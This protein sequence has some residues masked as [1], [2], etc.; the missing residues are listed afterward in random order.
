MKNKVITF[1]KVLDETEH[2]DIEER[3]YLLGILSKRLVEDKRVEISKRIKEAQKA[4]KNGNVKRRRF[5]DLWKDLN[6]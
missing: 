4:Y 3:E 2:L 1:D 5:D 6:D